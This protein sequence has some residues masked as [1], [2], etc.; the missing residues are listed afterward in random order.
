M[1]GAL[2]LVSTMIVFNKVGSPQFML[3]LVAVVSV[4]VAMSGRKWAVPAL[5]IAAISILTTL[6]YPLLYM[7]LITALNPGAALLLTVRN[8]LLVVL[9]CWALVALYRM[10]RPVQK[11]RR[12]QLAAAEPEP[13]PRLV[14]PSNR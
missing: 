1:V 9:L 2:A 11:G 7:Q 5:S 10:A 12:S 6:V 3:W 14:A 8:A 4:G 13:E